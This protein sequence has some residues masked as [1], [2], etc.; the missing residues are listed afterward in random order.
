MGIPGNGVRI[1]SQNQGSMILLYP[2]NRPGWQINHE[3]ICPYT[4][5][6]RAAKTPDFPHFLG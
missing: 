4:D 6:I 3:E 2:D 5:F 1:A